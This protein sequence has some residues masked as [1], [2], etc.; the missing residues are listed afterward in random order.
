[1]TVTAP[2]VLHG[3]LRG[4]LLVHIGWGMID[5]LIS[6]NHDAAGIDAPLHLNRAALER[7]NPSVWILWHE[8]AAVGY[9]AHIVGP[10]LFTGE[11]TATCAAI[12][13]RPAHRDKV[14]KM[15]DDIEADLR[16]GGVVVINYSVPH[17]SKAGAFFEHVGYECAELVMR[18]RIQA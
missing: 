7:C 18:K 8:G 4:F 15:L 11:Q 6:E 10:H 14:R 16:A 3:V 5:H 17:L 1:M 9:C 2:P 13:V 12:Y